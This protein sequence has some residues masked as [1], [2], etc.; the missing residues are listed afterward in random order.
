MLNTDQRYY[1]IG[2]S[3]YGGKDKYRKYRYPLEA[4]KSR[5]LMKEN[6]PISNIINKCINTMTWWH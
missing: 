4:L 1:P 5:K 3:L 2:L 6:K